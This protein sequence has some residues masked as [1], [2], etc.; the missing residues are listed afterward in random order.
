LA[1][2]LDIVACIRKAPRVG[3]SVA[4]EQTHTLLLNQALLVSLLRHRSSTVWHVTLLP[5]AFETDLR[6]E[7]PLKMLTQGSCRVSMC[8]ADGV[9]A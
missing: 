9:S 6:C 7:V 5:G 2:P 4:A 8:G 3:L 1:D